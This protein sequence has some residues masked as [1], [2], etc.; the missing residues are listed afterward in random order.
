MSARRGFSFFAGIA[1]EVGLIV[2]GFNW[3]SSTVFGIALIFTL[4]AVT[5][6]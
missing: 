5:D 2:N 6:K 1:L 4:F 3:V